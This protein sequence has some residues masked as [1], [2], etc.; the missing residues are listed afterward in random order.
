M[1][2]AGGPATQAGIFYQNSVAALML[3]DLL[4][5]DPLPARERVVE[6][7][8]EAPEDV[9][10]VVIRYADDH[11]QFLNV[12][13]SLTTGNSAWPQVWRSLSQQHASPNFGGNDRLTIVVGESSTDSQA[14]TGLCERAA[15]SLDERELRS[16][17]TRAQCAAFDSIANI[18][19]SCEAALDL[20][21]ST[22]VRYLSEAEIQSELGRRRLAGGQTPPPRLLSD[23]RD[24]AGG[25]ARRRGLF[26][27]ASL[28]RKLKLERGIDLAE[29]P[30][31]GLASYRAMISKLSRIEVPGK[32]VAG[33]TDE[34]FVWPRA[35]EYSLVRRT[36]FEDEN[37]TLS[38]RTEEAGID[39]RIFPSESLDRVII[40]AGPGYGKSALLTA[41]A[42][43]LAGGTFVPVQIPLA[44]WAASDTSIME[45]LTSHI[46]REMDLRA[47]WQ[48]LAEQGVLALLLDGLDEVPA[49]ARPLLMKRLSTFTARY[50]RAPWILTVRD[51]AVI[52][53]VS[54]AKVVEL[55]PL[56][57]QDIEKFVKAMKKYVGEVDSWQLVHRLKLYPDL[58]QLARIPLFLAMLLATTDLND[59]QPLTRSDLIEGYLKTLF[60]PAEH[61]PVQD[62]IDRSVALRVIAETLAYE[63]LERQ[64]IGATEREVREVIGRVTDST[65]ETQSL[66]EQLTANGILRQQSTIR[67]QFPY[68]IVQEY[69]AARH[70]I[71]RYPDSVEQRIEDAIQRPWAQVIQF[72]LEM[73]PAPAPI[74]HMMLH[75][76]DDAFCTCLRLVG[77]CIANGAVVDESLR[78]DVGNRLVKYWTHAPTQSREGVGRLLADG[79]SRPVSS[80]LREAVHHSWL[81]D[82]GAGE[83]VCKVDD[84]DLTLSVLCSLME[85]SRNT[86]LI[87]HSLKPALNV[88][89]DKALQTIIKKMDPDTL[90]EDELVRLSSLL[91]NFKPA[92]LSREL[93]LS[94]AQNPRMPKRARMEA[95]ELAGSPLDKEAITL[96]LA[97]LR[98]GDGSHYVATS[99][100]SAHSNPT[101]FLGELLRD[102]SIP[103]HRRRE[104]AK[105]IVR[106]LPAPELR[107]AFC[108]TL[109]ADS[110]IDEEIHLILQ[111]VEARFG[112]RVAFKQLVD[113]IDHNPIDYVATTIA[114]FG[115][116]PDRALAEY[117][118][119]LVRKRN[120][121]SHEVAQVA[122]SVTTGMLYV[123]EM[124]LGFG[125]LVHHASPHPGIA[126][127]VELLEY[128]T[129]HSDLNPRN[130]LAVLAAGAKLGSDRVRSK[131]E[132]E[133]FS[134]KDLDAPEW[135]K[136]DELGHTLSHALRE[137][138]L[139]KYFLPVIFIERILRSTR[140]NIV[141]RGVAALEMLDNKTALQRL[142]NFHRSVTDWHLRDMVANTLESMAAKQGL[143]L[144]REVDEYRLA[145]TTQTRE[146]DEQN[147]SDV[148]ES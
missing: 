67:L 104:I 9:D 80:A 75:R 55:L 107:R 106:V 12:K 125:G 102:N 50:P 23:L 38:E 132:D 126:S 109:I 29:P 53:A 119:T 134:I 128:W 115:H 63:R 51:P 136:D 37:A 118:V 11:R 98:A 39:L 70:L 57:D 66:F 69:L 61:K 72:A 93:V 65:E 13:L 140:Y 58:N 145:Y 71:E 99:M 95:Y 35:R 6:V 97:A 90:D 143:V 131:L 8:V 2:E 7:R 139:R 91:L 41:I 16:R 42:G 34:L 120:L 82:N 114:L 62:P 28:R 52:T 85:K 47:D 87:Y 110:E 32:G 31:W 108:Q 20:L 130:R 122:N 49:R 86:F 36:D 1:P 133:V 15:F 33:S 54:D 40:V 77:R 21:R 100:I 81:I 3:A 147:L 84:V 101:K 22:S 48:R 137:I 25:L 43:H 142:I 123:Y 60:S 5:F 68:P 117:A 112:D 92:F 17:L 141:T 105:N 74:I 94:I 24:I 88:A 26:R 144:L 64:E 76:S 116:F 10:D 79:F 14:L 113:G 135:L 45:F 103:V 73:H 59:P 146:S 19:G 4:D 89:G 18:V 127:W 124:D 56:S 129:D 83:I 96:V 148:N 30:E 111:L 46:S 44:S 78:L 138:Q 121:L 27:A